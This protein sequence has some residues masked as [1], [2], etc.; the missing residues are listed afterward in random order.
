MEE[1][2]VRLLF[3]PGYDVK[4]IKMNETLTDLRLIDPDWSNYMRK[5]D[6]IDSDWVKI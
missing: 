3:N 5:V 1:K 4:S 2:R 6:Q